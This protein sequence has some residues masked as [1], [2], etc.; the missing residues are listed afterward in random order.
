LYI[1]FGYTLGRKAISVDFPKIRRQPRCLCVACV[2]ERQL[3]YGAPG[4]ALRLLGLQF[5]SREWTES[6][7]LIKTKLREERVRGTVVAGHL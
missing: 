2:Y 5:A 7:G 4:S 1:R 3:L 6:G